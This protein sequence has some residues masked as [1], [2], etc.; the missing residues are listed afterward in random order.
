M[1]AGLTAPADRLGALASLRVLSHTGD[2]VGA[3]AGALV[4][5]LD[6]SAAYTVLIAANAL[7][8]LA[9]AAA[10]V[11]L[12][13]VPPRVPEAGER[14]LAAL[15]DGS[16]VALA[17][18]CG[19]LTLCWAMV[20]LPRCRS[21]SPAIRARRA[22][23]RRH[24]RRLLD[25]DRRP[26]GARHAR[27]PGRPQA[28][29]RVALLSGA[30]LAAS[31]VLF[32]SA[33]GPA[34]QTAALLLLAGGIAHIAGELLFVAAS[35]GLSVPLMPEGRAGQY[36]GVFATGEAAAL[37]V[38]PLLMTAVV[39]GW[40]PDRVDRAGRPVRARDAARARAHPA[41]AAGACP[42]PGRSGSRAGS[43]GVSV[44]CQSGARAASAT[45]TATSA[46]HDRGVELRARAAR[47]LGAGVLE[48]QR[49]AVRAVGRHRVE[50]VAGADDPR[51]D[52][53]VVAGEAV[54]VAGAV[55][56]LVAG[57]DDPPTL[58][59]RPPTCSSIRCPSTVC[60][61]HHG[62]LGVVE[63][64]VLVDDLVRDADLA[65]VVEERGQLH[66]ALR[67]RVE[68]EVRRHLE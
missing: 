8:Y 17:A 33:A 28:A 7:S 54:G 3:A 20:S 49:L 59:S 50:G 41:G 18:I 42:A 5:Q 23:V 31:C 13:H 24:R 26:A 62:P 36:Q 47:E 15:R 9:H 16:Y 44:S 51:L 35:W 38:A 39:V 37:T 1:I 22:R 65:Y 56:A 67:L 4:I 2:A 68:A 45:A 60:V 12:P 53:D 11:R 19:V 46:S 61:L 30:A 6:T 63:R 29:A 14:R 55:P 40:G 58:A 32:A 25:R 52:R 21:G 27:P 66:A 64:A 43:G 57:A 10:A 34:A 48:R